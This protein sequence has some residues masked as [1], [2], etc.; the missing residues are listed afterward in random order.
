MGLYVTPRGGDARESVVQPMVQ[1]YDTLPYRVIPVGVEL[2]CRPC[3]VP[4]LQPVISTAHYDVRPTTSGHSVYIVNLMLTHIIK[5]G[6]GRWKTIASQSNA[7]NL[8]SAG[9]SQS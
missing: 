1:S 8:A 9:D 5:W 4:M 3:H 7:P 6:R 2:S